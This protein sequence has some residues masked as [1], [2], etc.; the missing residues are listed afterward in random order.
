MLDSELLLGVE[1]VPLIL[2]PHSRPAA[3]RA[4][5]QQ[6]MFLLRSQEGQ[7]PSISGQLSAGPQSFEPWITRHSLVL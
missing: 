6:I 4:H 3:I 5:V 7:E 2:S 1:G